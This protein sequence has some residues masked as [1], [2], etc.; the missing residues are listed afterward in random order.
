[1]NSKKPNIFA[2][3]FTIGILHLFS[4][5][6][7]YCPALPFEKNI[8]EDVF[9]SVLSKFKKYHPSGNLKFHNVGIFP[10]LKL[11][12]L[13]GKILS[14]ALKLNFTPNTLRCYGLINSKNSN[15]FALFSLK[16]VFCTPS[17]S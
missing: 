16:L 10:S 15:I 17:S 3:F 9:G 14:I 4:W 1:M 13:M 8:L 11:R 5:L 7:H 6:T 12:N 2:L